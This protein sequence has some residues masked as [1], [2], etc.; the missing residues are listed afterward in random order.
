MRALGR[1][2][3]GVGGVGV[4]Q[5]RGKALDAGVASHQDSRAAVSGRKP[6]YGNSLWSERRGSGITP[7]CAGS[8]R[9]RASASETNAAF[10]PERTRLGRQLPSA[11]GSH[12]FAFGAEGIT[13]VDIILPSPS[14]LSGPI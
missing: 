11:A 3:E 4:D 14:R 1:D 8:S 5:K 13:M 6:I 10:A 7:A 9:L 12:L 2:G